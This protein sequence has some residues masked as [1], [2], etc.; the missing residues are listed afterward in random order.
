MIEREMGIY[1]VLRF[2]FF[3]SRERKGGLR[4]GGTTFI[5]LNL[6]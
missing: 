5:Y 3:F 1:F 4:R 6:I 2:P